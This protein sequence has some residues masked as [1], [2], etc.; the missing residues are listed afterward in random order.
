MDVN[1]NFN[2]FVQAAATGA[3]NQTYGWGCE[4]GDAY[5]SGESLLAEVLV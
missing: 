4:S 2:R 5:G 3:L 1:L